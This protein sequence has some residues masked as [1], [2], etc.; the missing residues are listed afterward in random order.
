MQ[1]TIDVIVDVIT[2][3]DVAQAILDAAEREEVSLIVMGARG[4]NPIKEL[5]L[6]SVSSA[7]LRH[8]KTSVLVL[9]SGAGAVTGKTLPAAS[10]QRLFFRVLAPTDFSSH[11]EDALSFI[12]KIPGIEEVI[13]L[14]VVTRVQ[15]LPEIEAAV[16]EAQAQLEKT[17]KDFEGKVTMITARIRVGDPADMIVSVAEEDRASLIAMNAFG[18]DWLREMLLGSTTFTV[19]RRTKNPVLVIRMPQGT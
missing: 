18:T 4:I 9:H 16:A 7:V 8:A 6:G 19:V 13:L 3:G 5:L 14:H 2:Q 15:S 17:K 10:S 1:I 12:K 11:A